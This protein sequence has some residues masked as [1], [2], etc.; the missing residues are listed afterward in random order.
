MSERETIMNRWRGLVTL[1]R[2]IVDQGSRAVE[3]VQTE[4][5]A[6]AATVIGRVPQLRGGAR[7]AQALHD[8]VVTTTHARVR[9]IAEVVEAIVLA[10]IDARAGRP[11]GGMAEPV[12]SANGGN[13]KTPTYPD[14]SI[15]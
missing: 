6:R 7:V 9:Q 4:E 3:R 10:G 11:S 15:G 13:A 5:V 14:A 8:L 2:T 12:S 1:T